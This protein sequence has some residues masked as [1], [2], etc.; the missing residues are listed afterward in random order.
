MEGEGFRSM[1]IE[2]RETKSIEVSATVKRATRKEAKKEE[3]FDETGHEKVKEEPC[4]D[5]ILVDHTNRLYGVFDGIGGHDNGEM[6]AQVAVDITEMEVANAKTETKETARIALTDA[7]LKAHQIITDDNL[8]NRRRINDATSKA[9]EGYG[10]MG[11][12]ATVLKLVE[13]EGRMYAVIASIGDS[14]AHLLRNGE[15]TIQT[16]D[17][18]Y[19]LKKLKAE[20]YDEAFVQDCLAR[21]ETSKDIPIDCPID[22]LRHPGRNVITQSIGSLNWSEGTPVEARDIEIQTK[23]ITLE[24]GDTLVLTTDGIHDVL[25]LG[26]MEEMLKKLPTENVAEGFTFD[27]ERINNWRKPG[28]NIGSERRKDDDRAVIVIKIRFNKTTSAS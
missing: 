28:T 12:T 16:I 4:E 8:E 20:G 5:K 1:R 9:Y 24:D 14:R 21:A 2:S 17:D 10:E 11:T 3:S 27:I 7:L 19:W 6:A 26:R 13:E 15:M 25:T 18:A 23:V 22:N